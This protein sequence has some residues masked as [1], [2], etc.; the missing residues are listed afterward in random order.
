LFKSYHIEVYDQE[1]HLKINNISTILTTKS[2]PNSHSINLF[3]TFLLGIYT[4]PEIAVN[5]SM[6]SSITSEKTTKFSSSTTTTSNFN[7]NEVSFPQQ[8]APLSFQQAPVAQPPIQQQKPV[9]QQPKPK[10]AY[11]SAP[12]S[13]VPKPQTP[14]QNFVPK[15]QTPVQ[16]VMKTPPAVSPAPFKNQIPSPR[17]D[18]V[19]PRSGY[20]ASPVTPGILK[21]QIQLDAAVPVMPGSGVPAQSPLPFG[22]SGGKSPV[23]IFNTPPAPFGF[24]PLSIQTPET[25]AQQAPSPSPLVPHLQYP[26]PLPLI[27]STPLPCYSS[28]YNNAARPFNEF[29]DFY[30]P[31]N[32]DSVSH[33]LVPPVIYTDF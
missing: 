1:N 2:T 23:P 6:T 13:F 5:S 33:K 29:K 10:P 25:I 31:I 19:S 7:S 12:Q 28:S 30:R 18:A 3:I 8:S 24:P 22:R 17:P 20:N 15:P 14:V 4:P 26:K 9:Q 32:M 21:K 27:V 16:Q 11:Q